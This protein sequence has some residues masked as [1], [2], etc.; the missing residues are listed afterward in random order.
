MIVPQYWA[1]ARL[2]KRTRNRQVTIRRFGWSDESQEAAQRHAEQRAQ[3]AMAL[4][5]QNVHLV[6]REPR[7]AYN[8]AQGVPIREEIVMRQGTSIITRN[9]YGARC[10]NTPNVL[11]ADVDVHEEPSASMTLATATAFAIVGAGLGWGAMHWATLAIV[12]VTSFFVGF[13][14]AG[15][16]YRWI[17]HQGPGIEGRVLERIQR[18]I[19]HHRDWNVRVYRTPAGLRVLALH[20]TFSPHD[21]EVADFFKAIKGDPVYALMCRNQNCFRARVSAKPWR[22]GMSDS[23]KPRRAVWPVAPEKLSQRNRWISQYEDRASSYAACRLIDTLGSG[24]V[25]SQAR[26]VQE[27][28]DRL[29]QAES[30]LPLA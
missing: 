16:L 5:E 4:A 10:L 12:V 26:A 22:I 17:L 27:L 2:Q 25:D 23:I 21:A 20:R 3:E 8:G 13:F 6:R 14:L 19:D 1:E 30:S 7:Q 18:F 15:I 28:H 9:S 24:Q 11:F 29:C